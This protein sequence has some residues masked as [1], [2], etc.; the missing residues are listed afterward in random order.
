MGERSREVPA[1][2]MSAVTSPESGSG[3][4]AMASPIKTR[5]CMMSP[6]APARALAD[7]HHAR[8]AQRCGPASSTSRT[9]R[10]NPGGPP[11]LPT[12]TPVSGTRVQ[13]FRLHRTRGKPESLPK[14]RRFTLATGK[15]VW[16]TRYSKGILSHRCS[17]L[18]HLMISDRPCGEV[19]P[20]QGISVEHTRRRIDDAPADTARRVGSFASTTGTFAL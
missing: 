15:P 19:F 18:I 12:L 11:R 10:R 13:M 20:D 6:G 16:R 3:R 4:A 9:L 1:A 2:P 7:L 5:P 17:M 14:P 8:P